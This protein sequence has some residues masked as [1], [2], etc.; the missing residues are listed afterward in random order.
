MTSKTTHDLITESVTVPYSAAPPAKTFTT[1]DAIT[2]RVTV[3]AP[4]NQIGDTQIFNGEE[5][6][7]GGHKWLPASEAE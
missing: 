2:E 6:L 4:P 1:H 7:W 3:P 5:W